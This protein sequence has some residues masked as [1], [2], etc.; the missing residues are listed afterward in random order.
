[1]MTDDAFA[2]E[3]DGRTDGVLVDGRTVFS[4]TNGWMGGWT[5]E[6]MRL[7]ESDATREA[8]NQSGLFHSNDDRRSGWG[9]WW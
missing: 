5:D 8:K 3:S 2:E 7:A 6:R 4:W 1:M 9:R